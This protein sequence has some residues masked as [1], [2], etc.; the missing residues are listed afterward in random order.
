ML[1]RNKP[2]VVSTWNCQGVKEKRIE[3]EYFLNKHKI[4]IMLL[5][6]TYLKHHITFNISNYFMYR[7]DR[8]YQRGGGVAIL[9]K[10][11]ISHALLPDLNLKTIESLGIIVNISNGEQVKIYSCYCPNSSDIRNDIIK[12]SNSGG[13][14]FAGGDFN[15]SHN[16]WHCMRNNK[17]GNALN[18]IMQ[19]SDNCVVVAP[20]DATYYSYRGTPN[21]LDLFLTNHSEMIQS[22]N[23]VLELNSDHLPVICSI[24]YDCINSNVNSKKFNY[25]YANWNSYQDIIDSDIPNFQSRLLTSPESID[26]A[27]QLVTNTIDQA[28]NL[29]IPIVRS[30]QPERIILDDESLM[31]IRLRNIRRR[32]WNRT[33]H[34]FLKTI[35][36]ELNRTIKLRIWKLINDKW[37]RRLEELEAYSKSFWSTA[38]TLKSKPR[39]IPPLLRDDGTKMITTVEKT[40][41]FAEVFDFKLSYSS[42]TIDDE[43]NES[44][45]NI[46]NFLIDSNQVDKISKDEIIAVLKTIRPYKSPGTDNIP[47]ILLK[48]LPEKG[49]QALMNIFNSCLII[50]YFPQS[51]KIARVIPIAKPGK[52]KSDPKNYRPISLLN[53]IGKIFEKLLKIR[54]DNFVVENN[55]IIKEQFGF[56]VQHSTVHQVHRIIDFITT[57]RNEQKSTGMVL[58]DLKSAFDSVWIKGI[59]FKLLNLGFPIYLLKILKSF[60]SNRKFFVQ[61]L[62]VNSNTKEVKSGVP[63]GAILSPLLFNLFINDV[64]KENCQIALFADDMAVF[65]SDQLGAPILRKIESDLILISQFLNKW[66]LELNTN[67]CEAIFFTRNRAPRKL[68][69]RSLILNGANLEWKTSVKYLGIVLDKRITLKT[70]I[71]FI[72]NKCNNVVKLL[73]PL[74][75]RKSKLSFFNKLLLYKAMILPIIIYGAPLILRIAKTN[76]KK[77]QV[78][79]NKILKLIL[80]VPMRFRTY[81]LHYLCKIEPLAEMF[82]KINLNYINKLIHIENNLIQGLSVN[83]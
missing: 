9:I 17:G 59:I 43:V 46:E 38:K 27:I 81:R 19:N 5:N 48:R 37:Q 49:I 74:L 1:D 16:N 79:Q 44:F 15:C 69:N 78:L 10:K 2:L 68:P 6:E 34:R 12:I 11:N 67:K 83:T 35:V 30:L 41:A 71:E 39:P 29:S 47:N 22:I 24:S 25:R 61:I 70:H 80:Q 75:C 73:Y 36:N 14:Y 50:G 55:I 63:Q 13:A 42:H 58:L 21:I 76:F 54:I 65:T 53:T 72:L 28:R 52:D 20:N 64:P 40:E 18:N 26:E 33:R 32:Q 7:N 66:K 62:N 77:L 23:T 45:E 3:L 82:N 4:D 56:R 60:L 8:E 57:N 31:L 51:W